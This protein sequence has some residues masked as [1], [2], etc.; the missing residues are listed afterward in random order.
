MLE[1]LCLAVPQYSAAGRRQPLSFYRCSR[2]RRRRRFCLVCPGRV[3]PRS[4]APAAMRVAHSSYAWG[5]WQACK[6]NMPTHG[7]NAYNSG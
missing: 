3:L 4:R 1:L 5:A 7:Q 2:H 6:N